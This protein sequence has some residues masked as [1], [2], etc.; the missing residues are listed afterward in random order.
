MANP[1]GVDIIRFQLQTL[2]FYD[3]KFASDYENATLHLATTEVDARSA[4]I[5]NRIKVNILSHTQHTHTQH[6]THAH[7]CILVHIRIWVIWQK[8]PKKVSFEPSICRLFGYLPIFTL[9]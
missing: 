5:S 4:D 8:F 2:L 7:T 3:Q 1:W 9:V 6:T